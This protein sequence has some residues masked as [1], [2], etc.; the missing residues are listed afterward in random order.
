MDRLFDME[1][2]NSTDPKYGDNFS[3]GLPIELA[4]MALSVA[5]AALNLGV[6]V[7]IRRTFGIGK[8]VFYLTFLDSIF[9]LVGCAVASLVS[10][11]AHAS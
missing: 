6:S 11:N 3:F 4:L 8:I 5:G 7:N 9:C 1:R 2:D 10:L